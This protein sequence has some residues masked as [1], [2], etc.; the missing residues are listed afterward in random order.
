MQYLGA[1]TRGDE[2]DV[3]VLAQGLLH[4]ARGHCDA[5]LLGRVLTLATMPVALEVHVDPEV[6][7]LVELELL[8]LEVPVPCG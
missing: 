4:D 8:H 3:P 2:A 6:R 1:S 7:R 5:T